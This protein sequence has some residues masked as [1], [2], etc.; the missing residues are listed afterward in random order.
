MSDPNQIL[1]DIRFVEQTSRL[2]CM[3]T[4][5]F[6]PPMLTLR[7]KHQKNSKK[8]QK[9]SKMTKTD[10]VSSWGKKWQKMTENDTK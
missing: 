3:Y 7:R 1:K 4:E 10:K 9:K 5:N 6:F 8:D 2:V